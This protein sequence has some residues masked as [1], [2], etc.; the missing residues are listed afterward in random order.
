MQETDYSIEQGQLVIRDLLT[1]R[2]LRCDFEAAVS[3]VLPVPE[4][5]CLVLLDPA[6]TKRPTF[7]NLF[8]VR[9]DGSVEWK[10]ELPQSH[11]AYVSVRD[12]DGRIEANTWN[13]ER[14]EIDLNSGRTKN[15]QFVK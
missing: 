3:K 13:G 1:G 8:R 7:E 12:C 4:D 6:A 11:D 15:R 9:K 5:D 2:I 14:V 10:A